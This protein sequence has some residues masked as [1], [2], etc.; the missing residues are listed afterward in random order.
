MVPTGAA[1]GLTLGHG[2]VT[3]RQIVNGE[4][5]TKTSPN[6]LIGQSLEGVFQKTSNTVYLHI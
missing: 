4:V 5:F 6:G 2:A 3:N 1:P